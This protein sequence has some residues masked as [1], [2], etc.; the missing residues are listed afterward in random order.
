[1]H[2]YIRICK[3]KCVNTCR[4]NLSEEIFMR[5]TLLILSKINLNLKK[6][7]INVK[8]IINIIKSY[9]SKR[10]EKGKKRNGEREKK[11][12]IFVLKN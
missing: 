12:K 6:N 8:K 1:M 10:E 3:K 7:I 11:L 5:I 2:K 9:F 4:Y